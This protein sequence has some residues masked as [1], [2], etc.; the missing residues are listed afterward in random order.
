MR[1][2]TSSPGALQLEGTGARIDAHDEILVVKLAVVEYDHRLQL[3]FA[4][5]GNTPLYLLLSDISDD[6]DL[7][8]REAVQYYVACADKKR[9]GDPSACADFVETVRARLAPLLIPYM[10]E[11]APEDAAVLAEFVGITH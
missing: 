9:A 11:S 7:A 4:T 3:A 5:A 10:R 6:V 1:L 8:V 2:M